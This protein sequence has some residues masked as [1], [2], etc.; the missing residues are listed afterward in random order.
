MDVRNIRELPPVVEEGKYLE[1]IW[2]LQ[3]KLLEGYIGK[4]EKDLPMYPIDIH[5]FKG[6]QV[7]KDFSARV[8]E[9]MAEG[10]ESTGL[11]LKLFHL[12]GYN[13]NLLDKNDVSMILNHLQ[14]SNEEQMDAV[15][16]YTA[17]FL[18]ANVDIKDIYDYAQKLV[19]D[20]PRDLSGIMWLGYKLMLDSGN[21]PYNVQDDMVRYHRGYNM[22]DDEILE[23]YG[24]DPKHVHSYIPA[25]KSL[26]EDFHSLEDHMLWAVTYHINVGRNFLKNKPWKQTQELTD[27]TRYDEQIVLGFIKYMG[28]LRFVGFTPETLHELFFKKHRVNCFRQKSGY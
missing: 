15:A 13:L 12:R 16:F 6:Q 26:S 19:P 14:N 25:F 18:Y 7:L 17:L 9:E 28:Y 10:Y 27:V 21:I 4:I 8:I 3:K 1:S 20:V 5:S 2:S 24:Y 11:A 23:D 22:M